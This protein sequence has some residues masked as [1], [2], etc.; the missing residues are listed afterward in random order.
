[1]LEENTKNVNAE[2]EK[3]DQRIAREEKARIKQEKTAQ[4]TKL[5][6]RKRRKAK[7][8]ES[9]SDNVDDLDMDINADDE[10]DF[11]GPENVDELSP[12]PPVTRMKRRRSLEDGEGESDSE[13]RSSVLATL[14][15]KIAF[16]EWFSVPVVDIPHPKRLKTCEGD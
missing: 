14:Q 6:Q 11:R 8:E 3:R 1:M 9:D 10:A 13:S 2:K 4:G 16:P 15:D 7:R 12:S 5:V